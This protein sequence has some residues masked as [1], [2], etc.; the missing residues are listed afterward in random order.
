MGYLAGTSQSCLEVDHQNE[1]S[2]L[3]IED[4]IMGA[5]VAETMGEGAKKKL[6][7]GTVY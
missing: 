5:A 4:L 3:T 7:L 2:L 6:V 1:R